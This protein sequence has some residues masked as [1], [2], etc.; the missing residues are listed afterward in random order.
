MKLI[1]LLSMEDAV[2]Q[3]LDQ[4]IPF[5]LSYNFA[6]LAQR[7][8]KERNWYNT[9]LSKLIEEYGLRDDNGEF[10]RT[11]DNGISLIPEKSEQFSEKIKELQDVDLPSIEDL[12]K[13]KF[14]DLEKITLSPRKVHALLPLIE[15]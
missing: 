6:L 11:E 5:A 1:T 4:D 10:V 15:K 2:T 7:L 13:F 3:I 12:P 14:T 8:E 9:Q